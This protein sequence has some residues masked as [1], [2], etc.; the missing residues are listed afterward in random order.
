[1]VGLQL[2]RFRSLVKN[3]RAGALANRAHLSSSPIR[4]WTKIRDKKVNKEP[5]FPLPVNEVKEVPKLTVSKKLTTPVQKSDSLFGSVFAP[6]PVYRCQALCSAESYRLDYMRILMHELAS[7]EQ[8]PLRCIEQPICEDLSPS[9]VLHYFVPLHSS[10]PNQ[11]YGPDSQPASKRPITQSGLNLN[12]EGQ[13]NLE[14][15]R[16][17]E[18]DDMG[19]VFIFSRGCIVAWNVP[20]ETLDVIHAL[21]NLCQKGPYEP[22]IRASDQIDYTYNTEWV[23]TKVRPFGVIFSAGSVEI[24]RLALE[25]YALSDALANS[26]KLKAWEGLLESHSKRL[27]PIPKELKAIRKLRV[28]E[29]Q[30]YERSGEYM[31]LRYN[32]N[33]SSDLLLPPD[34]YWDRKD[35]SHLYKNMCDMCLDITNRVSRINKKLSYSNELTSILRTAIGQRHTLKLDGVIVALLVAHTAMAISSVGPRLVTFMLGFCG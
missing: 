16:F 15:E 20:Q 6:S 17:I 26:V 33:I 12:G 10:N 14:R 13:T 30:I 9:H 24:Q 31:L 19:E 22:A 28:T 35:L 25:R 34:F 1:M 8:D 23:P 2:P 11:S 3:L 5:F 29:R 18:E 7:N 4:T 21:A 27:A 32:V